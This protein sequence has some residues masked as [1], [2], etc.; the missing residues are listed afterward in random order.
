MK[1]LL[2]SWLFF[3]SL[4]LFLITFAL[5]VP[6]LLESLLG[7]TEAQLNEAVQ[8]AQAGIQAVFAMLEP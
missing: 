7:N 5:V 6:Q 2:K 3:T 1:N 8:G 4:M